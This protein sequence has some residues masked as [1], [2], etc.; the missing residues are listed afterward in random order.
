MFI[1]DAGGGAAESPFEA[2][3]KSMDLFAGAAASGG[4]AVN[5]TGGKA[6]L[7]AIQG[8]RDWCF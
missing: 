4:F 8:M 2:I 3:G 6:L 5:E 7:Q 1:A